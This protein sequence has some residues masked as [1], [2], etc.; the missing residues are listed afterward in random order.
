MDPGVTNVDGF[1]WLMTG[2]D[3]DFAYSL[4][5][6]TSYNYRTALKFDRN[7]GGAAADE[8]VKFQSD[9]KSLNTNLATSRL[10]EILQ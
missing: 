8:P 9:W 2:V 10:H 3:P 6:K 4:S 5:G 1:R 7:L